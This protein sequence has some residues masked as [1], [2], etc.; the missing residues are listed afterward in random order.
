MLLGWL[1]GSLAG[2][3]AQFALG[4]YDL[5]LPLRGQ[6]ALTFVAVNIDVGDDWSLAA[7]DLRFALALREVVHGAQRSVP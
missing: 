2:L 6:P 3:L 5:P 7:T 4:Q 1:A